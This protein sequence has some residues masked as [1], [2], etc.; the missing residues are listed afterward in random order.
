VA[1]APPEC[2]ISFASSVVY[3]AISLMHVAAFFLTYTSIS[4]RQ[5][6]ILG[7]I[8]ASTTISARSTVC[9]EICARH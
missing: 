7:K 9:L 6:K 4:L 3:L 1:A 2:T 8:S 5:F